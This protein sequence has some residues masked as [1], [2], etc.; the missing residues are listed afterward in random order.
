MPQSELASILRDRKKNHQQKQKHSLIS[1]IT[2][3]MGAGKT[4]K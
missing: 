1:K 2:V 3:G 4:I